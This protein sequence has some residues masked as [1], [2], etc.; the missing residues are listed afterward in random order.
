MEQYR[1]KTAAQVAINLVSL[2]EPRLA[3]V[4]SAGIVRL[5]LHTAACVIGTE[6][7]YADGSVQRVHIC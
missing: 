2:L 7:P 5:P 3:L 4:V 1:Q 6:V